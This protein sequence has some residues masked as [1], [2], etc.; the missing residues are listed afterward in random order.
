MEEVLEAGNEM[1]E[2][3]KASVLKNNEGFQSGKST[4]ITKSPEL[5][6]E[7]TRAELLVWWKESFALVKRGS[8]NAI[9]GKQ[10]SRRRMKMGKGNSGEESG[11]PCQ[12]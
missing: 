3:T 11:V 1:V 8:L 5:S 9:W 10:K 12:G 6:L 7:G 2:R 4:R